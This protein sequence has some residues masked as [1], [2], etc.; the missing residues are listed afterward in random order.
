MARGSRGRDDG[1]CAVS[2]RA[3]ARFLLWFS[4]GRRYRGK[5][6]SVAF[7]DH[8]EHRQ[9]VR[10]YLAALRHMRGAP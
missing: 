5:G 10:I 6:V 2:D 1:G 9:L 8:A 4:W 3:R 7:Y